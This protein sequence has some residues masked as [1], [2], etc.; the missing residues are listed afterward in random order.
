MAI[1]CP[2]I[3]PIYSSSSSLSVNY[4]PFEGSLL[5][6]RTLLH[7]LSLYRHSCGVINLR[8]SA[9]AHVI[10]P[11]SKLPSSTSADCTFLA[12]FLFK[13]LV[14]SHCMTVFNEDCNLLHVVD[15][16]RYSRVLSRP[17]M[18]TCILLIRWRVV[19][20]NTSSLHSERRSVFP[21]YATYLYICVIFCIKI[22]HDDF[23]VLMWT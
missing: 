19:S 9:L 3:I 16:R 10:C 12:H 2:Q 4:P 18:F 20:L 1:S 21:Y 15:P 14:L 6:R 23:N 17:V 11:A 22:S 7:Y 5:V 8:S 13:A